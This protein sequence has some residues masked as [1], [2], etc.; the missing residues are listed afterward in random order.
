MLRLRERANRCRQFKRDHRLATHWLQPMM[1]GDRRWVARHEIEC[2]GQFRP[3]GGRGFAAHVAD[4]STHGC[5][6]R[7]AGSPLVGSYSWIT[8]P[9]LESRYARIAWCDGAAAGLDFAE[10]LHPAVAEMLVQR[11]A[12]RS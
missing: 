3:R 11:A 12:T 7:G 10:P 9:T 8:L 6:V 5:R 4:L 2:A 1:A